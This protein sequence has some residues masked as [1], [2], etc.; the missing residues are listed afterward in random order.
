MC[1][2]H[3]VRLKTPTLA[4]QRWHLITELSFVRNLPHLLERRKES[5]VQWAVANAAVVLA[6]TFLP[7][8]PDYGEV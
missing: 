2:A 8:P 7:T 3:L 1:N 6:E 4:L 5:Y